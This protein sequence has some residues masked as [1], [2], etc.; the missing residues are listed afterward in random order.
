MFFRKSPEPQVKVPPVVR[1]VNN[2]GKAIVVAK[3]M[4]EQHGHKPWFRSTNLCKVQDDFE[5]TVLLNAGYQE[6]AKNLVEN[7]VSV[8]FSYPYEVQPKEEGS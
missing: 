2:L 7:G 3:K 1:T 8:T 5:V 4:H 6:E